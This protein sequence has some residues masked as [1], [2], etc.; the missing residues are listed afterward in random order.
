MSQD[1]E[2]DGFSRLFATLKREFHVEYLK[3]FGFHLNNLKFNGG[4]R[5]CVKLA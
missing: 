2:S 3:L 5:P 4:V 1:F